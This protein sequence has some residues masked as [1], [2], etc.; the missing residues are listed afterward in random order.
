MVIFYGLFPLFYIFSKKE[1]TLEDTQLKGGQGGHFGRKEDIL[2][3]G[4]QSTC[5]PPKLKKSV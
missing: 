5:M 1:D 3:K 4:G 2:L